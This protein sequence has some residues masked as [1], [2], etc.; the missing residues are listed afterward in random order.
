MSGTTIANSIKDNVRVTHNVERVNL[1]D[2]GYERAG[3]VK[4]DPDVFAA[5]LER[6]I[7]GDLVEEI[8]SG[9]TDEEKRERIKEIKEL[10]KELKDR[11]SRN[12]EFVAEVKEK[13]NKIEEY[14]EQQKEMNE[15]V[16]FN[17]KTR[18]ITKKKKR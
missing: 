5:F 17:S 12:A 11:E 14:R 16:E 6:I 8:P 2:F 13:E 18:D 4:G 7:N 15:L 1:Y 10:E 3:A 9:F